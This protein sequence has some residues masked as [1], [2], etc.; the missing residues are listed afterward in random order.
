MKNNKIAG[1]KNKPFNAQKK[2]AAKGVSTDDIIRMRFLEKSAQYL[3]VYVENRP[4]DY[5]YPGE[6]LVN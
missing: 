3:G 5:L 1:N 4:A 2:N 6:H